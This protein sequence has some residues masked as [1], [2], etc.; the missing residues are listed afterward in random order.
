[1]RLGLGLLFNR[2]RELIIHG[3]AHRGANCATIP[4]D[5]DDHDGNFFFNHLER[6]GLLR[7]LGARSLCCRCLGFNK[8][9]QGALQGRQGP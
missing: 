5:E 3:P 2:A 1:M 6:G 8:S 9:A 4:T 7:Q